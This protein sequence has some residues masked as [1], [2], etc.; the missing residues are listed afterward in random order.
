VTSRRPDTARAARARSFDWAGWL[1]IA[2]LLV[3]VQWLPPDT[4]LSEV[5]RNGTLRVCMPPT[6]P[7][8]VTGDPR[9]PGLE[10]ELLRQVA[11]RL[12]VQ[13]A[14]TSRSGMGR[15][16]NP[17]SWGITRAQ[18][19]VL[20]GGVVASAQTRSFLDTTEPHARTGWMA[21]S[22]QPMTPDTAALRDRRVGV[23][24]FASGLDRLGL[25]RLLRDA[26]AKAVIVTKPDE[27]VAGLQQSRF[28]IGMTDALLARQLAAAQGWSVSW[29]PGEDDKYP[30]A[31]GLWKGDL[32]LKRAISAKLD[33]LA[34][35]GVTASIVQRYLGVS[36]DAAP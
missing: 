6:Y 33:E 30:L 2:G 22:P 36:R 29:L 13:L 27:L 15:D 24:A 31:F 23:L 18:C 16:F 14:I 26:N 32:T 11:D 3:A 10:V 34:R 8:L 20:A 4:S 21:L 12:G 19:E 9:R 28:D 7:P 25:S 1:F 35:D 5:R 17:L